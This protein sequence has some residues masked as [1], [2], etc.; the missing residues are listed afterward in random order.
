MTNKS[1]QEHPCCGKPAGAPDCGSYEH[2]AG[3][4][5]VW[6]RNGYIPE[7]GVWTA[8][9]READCERA[10][11]GESVFPGAVVIEAY[12]TVAALV[13]ALEDAARQAVRGRNAVHELEC[14]D[15]ELGEMPEHSDGCND[16]T[17]AIKDYNAL[18]AAMRGE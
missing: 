9:E 4:V 6:E 7:G 18:L 8:A 1:H 11:D 3:T 12:Q 17:D 16:Y 13:R 5:E 14:C 2:H 15:P 10:H